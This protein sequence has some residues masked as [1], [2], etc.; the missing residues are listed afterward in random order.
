MK[1]LYTLKH[2]PSLNFK[3]PIYNPIDLDITQSYTP[4]ET[5]K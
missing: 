4:L 3:S 5:N 1:L 2:D